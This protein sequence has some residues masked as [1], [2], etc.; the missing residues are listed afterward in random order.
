M[1][2]KNQI[3]QILKRSG[4]IVAFDK[5][6]IIN[7][8]RKAA[9]TVA[10]HDEALVN[11]MAD[12]VAE[13]LNKKFHQRSIPAVEEIQDI[14]EEVLIRNRQIK[15]A[16]AYILYRDQ[17][18]RLRDINEMVN[19]SELMEGYI[20]QV[21]WRVKENSNMS[22]SLQGLNNHIS[23]SISSRY[24]LNKVY[25][26]PIRDAYKNGD[27]HI[28]DLQLLSAYCAGW[29]LKDLLVYGFGGVTGKV[30]SKPPKHFRTALGQIVN[31]FYTLQGEVAGAEAFANFD[32]YLAPFIRHDN[33]NYQE[34]NLLTKK[35]LDDL[36]QRLFLFLHKF[37]HIQ[38]SCTLHYL[39]KHRF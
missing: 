18:A 25:S 26:A 33:L 15:T 28:H 2:P 14:V 37:L 9:Q 5:S 11:K 35:E 8:V 23:S 30:E 36:L 6:K 19:S 7:A 31:F 24:W 10:E 32:T 16:K 17:H 21:D 1:P 34:V 27:L 12:E 4:E 38:N 20:Q 13:M 22:Y 39:S 29:D 3:S